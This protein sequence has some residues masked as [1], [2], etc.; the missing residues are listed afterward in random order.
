MTWTGVGGAGRAEGV[1]VGR[2]LCVVFWRVFWKIEI[3]KI[4]KDQDCDVVMCRGGAVKAGK[5]GPALDARTGLTSYM[6]CS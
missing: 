1:V 2:V 3:D 6:I 4:D 5:A